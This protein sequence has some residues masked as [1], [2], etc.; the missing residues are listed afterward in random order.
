MTKQCQIFFHNKQAENP[1]A[2]ELNKL[3]LM[4]NCWNVQKDKLLKAIHLIWKTK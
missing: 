4:G 2:K 3:M 1:T